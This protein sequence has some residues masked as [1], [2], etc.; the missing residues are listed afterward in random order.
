[1]SADILCLRHSV[2]Q[3]RTI[4][5]LRLGSAWV[6]VFLSVPDALSSRFCPRFRLDS[7]A[8][9]ISWPVFADNLFFWSR[10]AVVRF[11]AACGLSPPFVA[12]G[13][14]NNSICLLRRW[15]SFLL[16]VNLC[17]CLECLF[18]VFQT[19]VALL[20]LWFLLRRVLLP[21]LLLWRFLRALIWFLQLL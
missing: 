12:R 3:R 2:S 7:G 6:L 10:L 18:C 21:V 13:S 17:S 14:G 5:F 16:C 1:M 9:I 15:F 11:L 20:S 4:S 19:R 8:F